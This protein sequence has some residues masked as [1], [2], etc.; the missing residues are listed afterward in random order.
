MSQQLKELK[1]LFKKKQMNK[2]IYFL[3]F[4]NIVIKININI[5]IKNLYII[6]TFK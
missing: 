5:Y 6:I 1:K 4:I 2:I 3:I